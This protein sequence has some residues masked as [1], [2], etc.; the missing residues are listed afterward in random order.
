MVYGGPSLEEKLKG[1]NCIK[2][3]NELLTH[4]ANYPET[5]RS[6]SGKIY[7][8]SRNLMMPADNESIVKEFPGIYE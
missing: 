4:Y 5:Y 1:M 6:I 2:C 8:Y 3:G 7:S